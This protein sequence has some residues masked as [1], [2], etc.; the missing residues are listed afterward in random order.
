METKLNYCDSFRVRTGREDNFIDVSGADNESC[1]TIDLFPRFNYIE[2]REKN[3]SMRVF[4]FE[5][6]S[7]KKEHDFGWWIDAEVVFSSNDVVHN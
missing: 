7:H 4:S 5:K 2:I 3:G 6:K 1:L